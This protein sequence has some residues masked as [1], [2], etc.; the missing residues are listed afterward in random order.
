[1]VFYTYHKMASVHRRYG[2]DIRNHIIAFL[3]V[4]EMFQA[5][6]LFPVACLIL[7]RKSILEI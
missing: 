4:K 2:C 5:F 1:M 6:E 3:S 7:L